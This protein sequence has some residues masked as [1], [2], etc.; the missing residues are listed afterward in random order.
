MCFE[1]WLTVALLVPK[2]EQ[3]QAGTLRNTNQPNSRSSALNHKLNFDRFGPLEKSNR[4]LRSK[5]SPFWNVKKIPKEILA[6]IWRN[7]VEAKILSYIW[8][9][10]EMERLAVEPNLLIWFKKYRSP[11]STLSPSPAGQWWISENFGRI[12]QFLW[13]WQLYD[14]GKILMMMILWWWSST[15]L[16]FLSF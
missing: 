4:S 7:T 5:V 8:W 3:I 9:R 6:K 15:P 12:W 13:R 10:L 1:D 2:I 11:L 16:V 14:D